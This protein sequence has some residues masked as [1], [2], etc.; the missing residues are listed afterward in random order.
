MKEWSERTQEW[1]QSL[2]RFSPTTDSQYIKGYAYEYEEGGTYTIYW[3]ATS[4]REIAAA[5]LEVAESLE[6]GKNE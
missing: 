2:G 5:C 1:M 4:L 3:D 6:G